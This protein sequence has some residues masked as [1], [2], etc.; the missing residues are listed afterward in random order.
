VGAKLWKKKAV[1]LFAD[2]S[3]REFDA[4]I[5]ADGIHSSVH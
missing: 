4:V 5:A 3:D 1:L 2:E